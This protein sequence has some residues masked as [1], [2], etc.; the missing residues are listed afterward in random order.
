MIGMRE[1]WV[2]K[3]KVCLFRWNGSVLNKKGK[4]KWKI[5]RKGEQE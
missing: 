4:K 2:I 1:G 3:R 5:Y